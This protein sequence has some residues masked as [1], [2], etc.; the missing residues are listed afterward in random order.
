M[1]PWVNME[2]ADIY[3]KPNLMATIDEGDWEFKPKSATGQRFLMKLAD[4]D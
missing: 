2:T 3:T 1:T 4:G